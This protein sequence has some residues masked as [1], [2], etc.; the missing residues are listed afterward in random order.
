MNTGLDAGGDVYAGRERMRDGWEQYVAMVPDHHVNVHGSFAE[1]PVVVLLGTARE[2]YTRDG[3]IR[4]E[5]AWSTP[6]AWRVHVTGKHV[7]AWRVYADNAPVRRIM[8][9][10]PESTTGR[11]A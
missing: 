7:V 3:T 9:V 8:E 6:A 5:H 10:D 4:P 11:S 1:G 2:T